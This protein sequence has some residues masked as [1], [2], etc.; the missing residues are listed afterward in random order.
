[1]QRA[2][3]ALGRDGNSNDCMIVAWTSFSSAAMPARQPIIHDVGVN[4]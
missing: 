2:A 4:F 3:T 1:M